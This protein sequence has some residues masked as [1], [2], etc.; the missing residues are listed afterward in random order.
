MRNQKS[1]LLK[2]LWPIVAFCFLLSTFYSLLSTS[3]FAEQLSSKDLVIR[4]WEA[5]GKNNIE[6]TFKITQRCI[7]LYREEAR[8]QQA[9]LNALPKG[10]DIANYQILNDVATC[11]FIQA[12]SYMRH[13]KLKQ[14]VV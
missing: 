8:Q 7:D 12:E 1:K 13:E 10:A 14:A 4:A 3:V 2:G 9:S 11:Y 5:H 6:E